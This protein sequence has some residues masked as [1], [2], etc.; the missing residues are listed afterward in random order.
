M[1]M[2]HAYFDESGKKSDHPVVTFSGVCVMQS[3]L[4]AFDAAWNTL[5]HQYG[6]RSLHMARASRLSEKHGDKMPRHQSA[7]Q[8]MDTLL[9]F[10]DCI[11]EH[12]EMGL[13]QAWD[14]AGFNALSAEAKRGIGSPDDP[15]YIAFSRGLTELDDYTQPDDRISLICDDDVMTALDCHRHY[16][17]MGNAYPKLRQKMVALTFANDEYFPALQ[18]ADMVAFLSRLEAKAQFYGDRYSFRRLFDYL[19]RERGPGKMIWK[20]L[21]AN[22]SM[23]RQLGRDLE[24]KTKQVGRKKRRRN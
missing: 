15:Y 5:L 18:A 1:A 20:Y 8:R 23:I 21:F 17:G 4:D 2:F 24:E 19:R 9:P 7:D 3:K 12:L 10:A 11:N 6:L 13:I 14:V 22:E 16:R